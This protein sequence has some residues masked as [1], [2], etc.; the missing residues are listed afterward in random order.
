MPEAL[1]KILLVEDS[2]FFTDRVSG[3]LRDAGMDVTTAANGRIGLEKLENGE[4]DIVLTDIEMPVMNGYEMVKK[5]RSNPKYAETR[6][7][8]LSSL[9]GDDDIQRGLDAGVDR[10][11]IKLDKSN[12][13]DTVME[14][15]N[16]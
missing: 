1:L 5:I 2:E 6:I 12:L 4:F 15:C 8:A 7:L 9:A 11:L 10:Y 3:Y 16:V 14:F 13:I